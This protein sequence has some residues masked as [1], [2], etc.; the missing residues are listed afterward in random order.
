MLGDDKAEQANRRGV[1][2]DR[3]TDRGA[4]R[5]VDISEQAPFR[6]LAPNHAPG[7]CDE[8]LLAQGRD[9]ARC[10]EAVEEGKEPIASAVMA[11]TADLGKVEGHVVGQDA[12]KHLGL[13]LRDRLMGL[14]DLLDVVEAGRERVMVVTTL[15]LLF[16]A[17]S[18]T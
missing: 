15:P 7:G 4:G 3:Q 10:W 13:G 5:L 17:N 2:R 1:G 12:V 6:H 18:G 14:R 8:R 9:A 16:A 11:K